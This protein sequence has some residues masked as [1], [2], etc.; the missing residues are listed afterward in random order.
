MNDD[1]K[2]IPFPTAQEALAAGFRRGELVVTEGGF[3]VKVGQRLFDANGDSV[4]VRKA[5]K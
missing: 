1:V 2:L 3:L 4:L 5:T